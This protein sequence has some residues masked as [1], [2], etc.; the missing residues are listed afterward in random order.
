MKQLYPLLLIGLMTLQFS[1]NQPNEKTRFGN[2]NLAITNV[3]IIDPVARKIH[4]DKTILIKEDTIW[5]ILSTAPKN[6]NLPDSLIINGKN[7]FIISGFWDMHTH[8]SWKPNLNKTLF[9]A[10]LSYGV[11]GVRDMGGHVDILNRFKDEI[12]E[13]PENGPLIFG[14]GPILDGEFPIHTDVGI[15]LTQHNYMQILDSLYERNV[16]FFKVYSLLPA[17]LVKQI[18]TYARQKNI[19]FAGHISEYLT[20]I[21]AANLKQKSFEHLNRLEELY[22]D[23]LA[24][25]QFIVAVKSNG[26][27]LCPTSIIFKKKLDI[28]NGIPLEHSLLEV[29]DEDLVSEWNQIKEKR[30]GVTKDPQKIDRIKSRFEK[31]KKLI[32][33]FYENDLPLLLGTD[34]G[35]MAFVYPGYSLHEEMAL[36]SEMGFDNF[37]ILKMATYEPTRFFEINELYGSVEEGKVADLV[38]L[39]ENPVENI[40]NSLKINYV[41][42]AGQIVKKPNSI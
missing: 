31:Q 25:M 8:I 33:I 3:N 32:K 35:G 1:C 12:V 39:N 14:C 7:K 9:P 36:M 26:N 27:W 22:E 23:S 30:E 38:V 24:L 37:D 2:N 42:R 17:D 19:S 34:F 28:A 10:Y 41:I 29:L 15:G 6:L 4:T 13:H 18:S 21:E 20:A 16:D 5:R 40:H 11:T